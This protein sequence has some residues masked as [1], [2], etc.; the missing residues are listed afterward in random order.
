[1]LGELAEPIDSTN[2]IKHIK[3]VFGGVVRHTSITKSQIKMI[4]LCGGSGSFLLQDAIRANAEQHVQR[5]LGHMLDQII[6]PEEGL[7][8]ARLILGRAR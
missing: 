3:Q 6:A 8:D 2:F 7:R 4:A 5:H 1:M